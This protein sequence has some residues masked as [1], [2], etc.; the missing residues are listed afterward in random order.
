M[1][2][3]N[4][5]GGRREPAATLGTKEMIGWCDDGTF[6]V[7][8]HMGCRK[9]RWIVIDAGGRTVCFERAACALCDPTFIWTP[10]TVC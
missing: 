9:R 7:A 4:L 5:A 2:I 1:G 8:D 3:E 10:Q 6:R